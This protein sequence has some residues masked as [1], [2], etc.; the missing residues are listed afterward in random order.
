MRAD[1]TFDG[2]DLR[3]TDPKFRNP[4][5]AEYVTAVQ[6][7]DRLAP[8]RFGKRAIHLAVRWM[9]DQGITT[10]LWGARFPPQ[11]QP[12][13]Q[14]IGWTLYSSAKAGI[15]LILAQTIAHPSR[16]ALNV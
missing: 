15:D 8:E 11:L 2:D 6:K 10:P 5:F 13:D 9:L 7:L 3:P 1:T 14:V 16:P 4:R 12:V